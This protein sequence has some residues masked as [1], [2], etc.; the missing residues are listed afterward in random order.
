MEVTS[1]TDDEYEYIFIQN[2]SSRTLDIVLPKTMDI[3]YGNKD[4]NIRQYETI[5]S[6]K[7]LF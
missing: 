7:K 1:R 3:I 2:F 6:R 5:V 4:G